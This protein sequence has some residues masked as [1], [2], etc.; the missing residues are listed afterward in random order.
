MHI[1]AESGVASHWLYKSQEPHSDNAKRLGAQWLQSLVDIQNET[2]DATEFWDYVKVDLFPDAVYVFTPKSKIMAL[3]RGATVVDFA[4]AVH[5][6]IGDRAMAGKINSESVPLRTELR[7][8]DVVEIVTSPEATPNPAWL[9]FVRTGRARSK[10]RHFLKTQA[11]TESLNLGQKLLAQALRAEGIEE[12]PSEDPKYKTLW[13]RLLRFTGSHTKDEL[14]TDVGIG[15]RVASIVAKRLVFLLS[16]QGERPNPLLISKERFTS[17]E[18]ISQGGVI[19]DGSENVSVQYGHCCRPIPGDLIL[20]YLG[21]G[22][23]LVVHTEDC[24]VG[25]RLKHKDNERFISVEW[26]D[27]ILR[28]FE[29]EVIV[30]VQNGKGVLARVATA[31]SGAEAD[32]TNITMSEEYK[33]QATID[34]KFTIAIR[35]TLHLESVLKNLRRIPIVSQA[36]RVLSVKTSSY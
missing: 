3:P 8:G 21:R 34:L 28:A 11:Q 16:E 33:A 31:I 12:L 10:I 36:K 35:D 5:S 2:H 27:E 17:H 14:L 23:G 18:T 30:T 24:S 1:V 13:D 6:N 19:V 32:I 7:N 22:E 9:G 15:K 26:A 25:Q 29:S 4:Y 20:G